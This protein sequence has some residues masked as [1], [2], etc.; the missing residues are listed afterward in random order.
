MTRQAALSAL[1]L[2]PTSAM[3]HAVLAGVYRSY[4]WNWAAAD[5]ELKQA[6]AFAP[7]DSFVLEEAASL[8]FVL[9]RWDEG[10]TQMNASLAVDPLNAE[11]WNTLGYVQ[12]RRGLLPE[13]EKSLRRAV[14]IAP[15][16]AGAHADLGLTLVARRDFARALAETQLESEP[17]DRDRALAVV[18][19][20]MKQKVD[21]DKALARLTEEHANDA[22]VYIAEVHAYRGEVDDAFHWLDR[23][24]LQRD[25]ALYY[26]KSN[27]NLAAINGDVRFKALLK[28]MN[29]PE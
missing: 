16:Y 4:D 7:R 29:L 21:S 10:F 13:S 1:T 8:S 19:F 22:A 24:Y 3:A 23:A 25:P 2:E 15:T 14:E 9:G 5:A 28:K 17:M 12:L 20:A 11:A 26:I 6:L 27:V 18:Y